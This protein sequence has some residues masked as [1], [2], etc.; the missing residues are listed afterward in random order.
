MN[1]QANFHR[2]IETIQINPPLLFP[3]ASK[4][5]QL[6]KEIVYQA[7]PIVYPYAIN[8]IL[9]QGQ[10]IVHPNRRKDIELMPIF[11]LGLEIVCTGGDYHLYINNF[12]KLK[13]VLESGKY[14]SNFAN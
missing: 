13:T 9:K 12:D 4:I 7:K 10:P 8:P 3:D 14:I 1:N 5:Y 6:K 2:R 11:Q